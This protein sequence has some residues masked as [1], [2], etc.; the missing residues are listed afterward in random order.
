MNCPQASDVS[1]DAGYRSY[2]IHPASITRHRSGTPGSV[3]EPQPPEQAEVSSAAPASIPAR[4][5]GAAGAQHLTPQPVVAA[6]QA[7]CG[8]PGDALGRVIAMNLLP[9]E[10][11]LLG[12]LG[13]D[14]AMRG[15][16][17]QMPATPAPPAAWQPPVIHD[18]YTPSLSMNPTYVDSPL[19]R[20]A[21]GPASLAA[22]ADLSRLL[23]DGAWAAAALQGTTRDNPLFGKLSSRSG[24]RQVQPLPP[25]PLELALQDLMDSDN[26]EWP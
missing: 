25:L 11:V 22:S 15:M 6:Q 13:Q 5:A 3:A 24:K 10:L 26:D 1:D 8:T 14:L 19:R 12:Q 18:S 2:S 21:S 9:A 17:A 4:A 7:G 23:P 16:L 20:P